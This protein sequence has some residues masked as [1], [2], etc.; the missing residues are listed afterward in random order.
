MGGSGGLGGGPSCFSAVLSLLRAAS[1]AFCS[2]VSSAV[3]FE[4]T[5]PRA[6]KDL[7]ASSAHGSKFR[8]GHRFIAFILLMMNM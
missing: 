7:R 6:A 3:P 4:D 8:A 5:I 1:L 2:G